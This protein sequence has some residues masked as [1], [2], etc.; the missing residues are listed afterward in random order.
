MASDW[1]KIRQKQQLKARQSRQ[2]QVYVF[3]PK[4]GTMC[5]W[6]IAGLLACDLYLVLEC[7]CF[8]NQSDQVYL[9]LAKPMYLPHY[10]VF[11]SILPWKFPSTSMA[12]SMEV[13][14]LG[15]FYRSNCISIPEIFH[16]GS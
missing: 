13:N 12:I 2:S 6:P 11:E 1:L 10:L 4:T 5:F 16:G 8:W 15:N 9:F 14:V 3:K 7:N